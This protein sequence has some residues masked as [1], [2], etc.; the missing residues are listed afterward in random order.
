M[1]SRTRKNRT[2]VLIAYGKGIASALALELAMLFS[3][4]GAEVRAALLDGGSDWVS[5]AALRSIC[6]AAPLSAGHRPGWLTAAQPFSAGLVIAPTPA[7]QQQLVGDVPADPVIGYLLGSCRQISILQHT[8]HLVACSEGSDSLFF[9]ELPNQPLRLSAFFQQVFADQTAR[10]AARVL[11]PPWRAAIC[12][13]PAEAHA[14]ATDAES[15]ESADSAKSPV[16]SQAMAAW[17]PRLSRALR[18]RHILQVSAGQPANIMFFEAGD[19]AHAGSWPPVGQSEARLSVYFIAPET[20][21]SSI[22]ADRQHIFVRPQA[23]GL[24]VYDEHGT[25]LLPDLSGRCCFVRLADYLVVSL[26][27]SAPDGAPPRS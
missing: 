13:M 27:R 21:E 22:R 5:E 25:R 23:N 26:G 15:G 17:L 9:A 14:V 6:G 18:Q 1:K 8:E 4:S 16:E 2:R 24:T 20:S 12:T 7:E 19:G 11:N 3:H 10:L